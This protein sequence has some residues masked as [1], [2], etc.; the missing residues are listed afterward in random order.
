[1]QEFSCKEAGAAC[2]G[3]VTAT[4]DE[5]LMRQLSQHLRDVHH[6]EPNETLLSYLA[7]TAREVDGGSR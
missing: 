1:M 7:S 6:V 2:S 5:D 3:H 4:N